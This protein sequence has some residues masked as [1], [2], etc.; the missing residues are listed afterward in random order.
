VN[1]AQSFM[2]IGGQLVHEGDSVAAEVTVERIGP[3]AAVLRAGPH[4]VEVAY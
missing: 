1:P 2:M 3:R 4:R